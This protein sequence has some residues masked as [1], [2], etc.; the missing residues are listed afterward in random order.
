MK[1]EGR[2]EKGR[3]L[4][5]RRRMQKYSVTKSTP[6][7]GKLLTELDSS[8]RQSLWWPWFLHPWD[9]IAVT[10]REGGGGLGLRLEKCRHFLTFQYGLGTKIVLRAD[11]STSPPPLPFPLLF[12]ARLPTASSVSQIIWRGVQ[13]QEKEKKKEKKRK[14]K[15]RPL[16]LRSSWNTLL[17]SSLCK[18][19][20]TFG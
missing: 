10:R 1:Q 9:P 13:L 17:Q 11:T 18:N 19:K 20:R 5:R 15:E 12:S 4:D 3:I 7:T 6:K 2:T 14:K 16:S 8:R